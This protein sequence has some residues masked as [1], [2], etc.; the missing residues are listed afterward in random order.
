MR[1]TFAV[2]VGFL[3]LLP[4][5]ARAPALA[6][7]EWV[8]YPYASGCYGGELCGGNGSATVVRLAPRPVAAVRFYAHDEVGATHRGRLRVRLDHHLLAREL[9]ISRRGAVIELDA[10]GLSGRD[11]HIEVLGDEEVVV[12][13]LEVR[14]ETP[15]IHPHFLP[16]FD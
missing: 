9:E 5:S 14:Y 15:E 11:L 16:E 4:L 2:T 3:L 7:E 6:A 13:D 1:F 8:P 12:E 10:V